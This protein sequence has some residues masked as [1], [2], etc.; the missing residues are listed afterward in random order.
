LKL[1]FVLVDFEN[2]QP[3][4]MGLLQG[5]EYKIKVFLGP[6]QAKISVDIARALQAFGPDAEYIQIDGHGSNA[7]D[8]H[9]AYYIG[10]LASENPGASFHIISKDTGFDPLIQHLKT[11][12]I[13]CHRFNS[14]AD[15]FPDKAAKS[16]SIVE[17]IDTVI[18][19]LARRKTAKPQKVKTLRS[20]INALFLKQL[21]DAELD[22]FIELLTK[23]K[24]IKI[25]DDKVQYNLPS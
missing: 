12:K 13:A 18:D 25:V 15:I 5:G 24:V 4:N 19:N 11:Q 3:K 9:I 1:N 7:L 10:R 20:T 14:I 23:R 17:K 21:S 2:V 16:V 22:K 8:F 6:R